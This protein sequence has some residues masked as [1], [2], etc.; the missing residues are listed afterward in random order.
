MS[1]VNSGFVL[2]LK[3][4]EAL[5]AVREAIGIDGGRSFSIYRWNEFTSCGTTLCIGGHLAVLAGYRPRAAAIFHGSFENDQ[6]PFID[7][8]TILKDQYGMVAYG[9]RR[10]SVFHMVTA[11]DEYPSWLRE[12]WQDLVKLYDVDPVGAAQQAI[13]RFVEKYGPPTPGGGVEMTMA[14]EVEHAKVV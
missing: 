8:E 5:K 2:S 6:T 4:V 10:C 13:D 1:E 7:I 11:L 14:E 3:A 9:P 12:G